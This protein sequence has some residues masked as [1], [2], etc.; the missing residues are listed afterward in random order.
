MGYSHTGF[1]SNAFEVRSV[2]QALDGRQECIS[3]K[4]AP[5]KVGQSLLE[6]NCFPLNFIP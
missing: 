6:Q 5:R 4:D 2:A 1:S 3:P